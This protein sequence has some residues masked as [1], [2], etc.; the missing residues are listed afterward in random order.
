MDSATS[1][2]FEDR[3]PIKSLS[4]L[5]RNDF[6]ENRHNRN[7]ALIESTHVFIE[8]CQTVPSLQLS[9]FCIMCTA[10]DLNE[11][12][13]NFCLSTVGEPVFHIPK[14][15]SLWFVR[16][17]LCLCGMRICKRFCLH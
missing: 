7:I 17:V 5:I 15:Y 4:K 3:Q 6:E 14:S 12:I 9:V 13:S 2:L 10:F 1:F 16:Y 11:H 8:F